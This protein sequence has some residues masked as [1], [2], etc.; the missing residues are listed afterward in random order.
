LGIQFSEEESFFEVPES[1]E[2]DIYERPWDSTSASR[3]GGFTQW[4]AEVGTVAPRDRFPALVTLAEPV[5]GAVFGA[6]ITEDA[7]QRAADLVASAGLT[8]DA[9]SGHDIAIRHVLSH[10]VFPESLPGQLSAGVLFRRGG[11]VV[12]GT[13]SALLRLAESPGVIRVEEDVVYRPSLN[14]V[15]PMVGADHAFTTGLTGRGVTVAVIDTG[16][17]STH[18]AFSGRISPHSR[19]FV[20]SSGAPSNFADNDGHGTHV[21]GIVGGDGSPSGT[22]R[23][24]APGADLLIL[25]AYVSAAQGG[26]AGDVAAAVN[27]AILQDADVITVSAGY[28]PRSSGR[29][30]APPWLWSSRTTFEEM[31]F[32]AAP[33]TGHATIVAA[34]NFGN[35]APPSSTITR[36]GICEHV[37]TVGSVD[38]SLTSPSLSS[39]SSQGPVRRSDALGLGTV[40]SA[41]APHLAG[42]QVTTLD[43]P[44]VL[45]P[46]G[47]RNHQAQPGQCAHPQGQGVMSAMAAGVGT[48]WST[49][50]HPSEPYT[51]SSGTSMA[52]P[53]AAG[54]AALITEY[55]DRNGLGLARR[56]DRALIVHNIIRATARD[57]GL[58][59]C[60]Q[61]YGL[62]DWT[63]IEGTLG[64]IA[65]GQ[66]FFDNYRIPPAF[67]R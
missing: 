2:D 48:P 51:S 47:E 21:A 16:I 14:S 42:A 43:K 52:A 49:C 29:S 33:A 23:G 25:K 26:S 36:P 41:N 65:S 62:V 60:K 67:P 34:G 50:A 66:D 55:A 64:Q 4:L 18:P 22:F 56:S 9:V 1:S 12:D 58:S 24:V 38:L 5:E 11:V 54:L 31:V 61:G 17:D 37:L 59:R 3:A 15:R 53:V 27:Y 6:D 8:R 13:A 44:D 45:A 32:T 63:G 10:L 30:T 57:L 46:G 19:N 35:L 40:D 7:Q 28:A 20:S 39:F